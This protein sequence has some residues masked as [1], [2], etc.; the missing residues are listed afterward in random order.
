MMLI[1]ISCIHIKILYDVDKD[2]LHS[3]CVYEVYKN[4]DS[5]QT[6]DIMTILD[7]IMEFNN[8]YGLGNV[9]LII[10]IWLCR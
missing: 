1:R 10:I 2:I 8:R 7:Y 3:Y 5:F 9:I 4:I 6:P